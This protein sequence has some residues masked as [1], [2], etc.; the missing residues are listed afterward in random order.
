MQ[1]GMDKKSSNSWFGGSMET[2]EK[3]NSKLL[4]GTSNWEWKRV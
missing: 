3:V 2:F 4:H 1:L